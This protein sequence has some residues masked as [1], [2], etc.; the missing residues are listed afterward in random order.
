M[1][2]GDCRE[3]RLGGGLPLRLLCGASPRACD[4]LAVV[5]TEGGMVGAR[6][7]DGALRILRSLGG[8]AAGARRARM[9]T[10]SKGFAGDSRR[11]HLFRG[12]KTPTGTH[13][14]CNNAGG[15]HSAPSTVHRLAPDLAR[16]I[17]TSPFHINSDTQLPSRSTALHRTGRGAEGGATVA[18]FSARVARARAAPCTDSL[19]ATMRGS[20]WRR[21][22]S[23]SGAEFLVAPLSLHGERDYLRGGDRE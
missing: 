1:G 6:R 18:I 13:Q 23:A 19:T 16:T 2:D 20:S 21:R 22:Q 10:L 4:D 12:R 14:Q 5:R 15:E 9:P 3:P 17:H 7:R 8:V 11:M